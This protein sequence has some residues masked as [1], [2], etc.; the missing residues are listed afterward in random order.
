MCTTTTAAIFES[1]ASSKWAEVIIRWGATSKSLTLPP[2][3]RTAAG[4]AKKVFVGTI[5]VFPFTPKQRRIISRALVP[6]LTAIV[7]SVPATLLKAD[8]NSSVKGPRVS[9]PDFKTL[10]RQV[11]ISSRSSSGIVTRAGG[12]LISPS[13]L[14]PVR[15]SFCH[16][17]MTQLGESVVEP[18][19]SLRQSPSNDG[20]PEFPK[21]A[22]RSYETHADGVC[23]RVAG[24]AQA[25]HQV[26]GMIGHDERRL[27]ASDS[28]PSPMECF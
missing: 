9:R 10:R 20:D 5:T 12:I 27:E 4:V 25:F 18:L 21:H 26:A 15:N 8:S 13:F 3:W 19:E 16:E 22:Y 24:P 11:V 1:I 2:A 17:E 7:Y 23:Y 14:A 28:H 6:L